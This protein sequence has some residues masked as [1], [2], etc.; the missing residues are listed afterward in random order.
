MLLLPGQLPRCPVNDV[1]VEQKEPWILEQVG[2][3]LHLAARP[4][5]F[6]IR[7]EDLSR[8]LERFV[9]QG[10]DRLDPDEGGSIT[11]DELVDF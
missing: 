4:S 9:G 2:D 11:L 1:P 8:Q 10:I 5:L 3:A 6:E 7:V